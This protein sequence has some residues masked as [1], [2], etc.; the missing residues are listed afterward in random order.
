MK[1]KYIT[2][3]RISDQTVRKAV[4]DEGLLKMYYSNSDF[5]DIVE[6]EREMCM[7]RWYAYL[8]GVVSGEEPEHNN[9]KEYK[10]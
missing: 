6:Y 2:Y 3:F 4:I 7:E 5:K 8:L 9:P 10:C 1:H